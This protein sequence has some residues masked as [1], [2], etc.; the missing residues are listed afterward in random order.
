LNSL[1]SKWSP[2]RI[3]ILVDENTKKACLPL[4][5]TVHSIIISIEHG[6]ENKTLATCEHIWNELTEN[7]FSRNSLLINLGGGV[8]GD[9]GGFVASTYKRGMRFV[10]VPT[11]LLS[12]VDASIGGKLGIDFGDFKNHIGLFKD[13]DHVI[14]NPEFLKTLPEKELKSGFAEVIKHCLIADSDQWDNLNGLNFE[15]LNWNSIIPQSI[16]IKNDVVSKDPLEN[17]LR[18]ILN[19]G[20]TLGH[21]IESYF[22]HTPDKLLHG[23]AIAIGMILES[24]L[25]LQMGLISEEVFYKIKSYIQSIFSPA[26]KIPGL[27]K[28]QPYLLQDK[29]N[30][31]SGINFSLITGI[32]SCGYDQKVSTEMIE[33]AIRSNS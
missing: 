25:S 11:T 3:A 27:E 29:K 26:N 20:H 6:E 8:I 12:Q 17:G 32:G 1:I 13:P 21:A 9:M 15:E 24:H 31:S 4:L 10:N 5:S 19:F 16:S 2:D 18:K 30:D 33:K 22:L 7:Q 23:E 14:V 28:L